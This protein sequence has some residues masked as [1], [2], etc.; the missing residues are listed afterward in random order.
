MPL[1]TTTCNQC[2]QGR[3]THCP[4]EIRFIDNP[5]D[6]C[7]CAAS[8][9]ENI[10]QN[11]KESP[12]IKSMLGRQKEERDIPVERKVESDGPVEAEVD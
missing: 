5:G 6:H 4:A 11:D 10:P 8:N 1:V 9:H 2:E 12:K 3:H 7:A